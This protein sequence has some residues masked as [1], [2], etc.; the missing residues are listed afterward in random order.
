MVHILSD[1]KVHFEGVTRLCQCWKLVS[2]SGGMS[3]LA[4]NHDWPVVFRSE[5][6]LPGLALRSVRLKHTLELAPEPLDLSGALNA[7]GLTSED[8]R[9]GVWDGA[10]V[11]LYDVDWAEP[12]HGLWLWS[13]YLTEIEEE[14]GAFR[15]RLASVKS[16][17]ERTIGRIFGRRCDA[18]LGDVRCGVSLESAPQTACDKR[19]AT[20]RDVFANA[21]NFRGF[22]HMPGNDAVIS[23][24]GAKRDGSSRGIER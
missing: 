10:G 8:L 16:D 7:E 11:T 5:T 22:P 3:V 20:C 15:A 19:F 9:A 21:E 14:G 2:R 4:T 13:G 1:T 24:P 23:G 12:E 18:D 6:Y 17:L